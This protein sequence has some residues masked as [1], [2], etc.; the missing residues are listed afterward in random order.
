MRPVHRNIANLLLT[1]FLL[2]GVI[3]PVLHQ[4]HHGLE[5]IFDVH[6]PAH[7]HPDF[8]SVNDNSPHQKEKEF[9]CVLCSVSFHA[10]LPNTFLSSLPDT[11]AILP[12]VN[13]AQHTLHGNS[14]HIRGPPARC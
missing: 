10:G 14:F 1:C 3:A 12:D 5:A 13:T 6:G 7:E 11:H 8:D 2:G 9:S 4:V